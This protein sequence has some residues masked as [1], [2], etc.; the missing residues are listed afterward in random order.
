MDR[1]GTKN[2]SL[3]LASAVV[4]SKYQAMNKKKVENHACLVGHYLFNHVCTDNCISRTTTR[5]GINKI[6]KC[7]TSPGDCKELSKKT[8]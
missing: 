1:K 8:R 3:S 6:P 4:V 7:L 2:V 5:R